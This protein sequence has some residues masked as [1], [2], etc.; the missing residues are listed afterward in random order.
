MKDYAD[1]E[2]VKQVPC[3]PHADYLHDE[4]N[5]AIAYLDER[6]I[7]RG[8]ANCAHQYTNTEGK[9]IRTSLAA[10]TSNGRGM[11]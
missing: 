7:N 2:W 10:Y 1:K 8:R 5:K 3:D 9:V 11:P 6:G 4:L